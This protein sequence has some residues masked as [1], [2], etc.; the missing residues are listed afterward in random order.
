LIA[1]S[2]RCWNCSQ[3]KD[4]LAKLSLGVAIFL[5]AQLGGYLNRKC[6][7]APGFETLWKGY[8]RFSDMVEII[9]LDRVAKSKKR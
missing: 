5:I 9:K 8:A 3:K 6:D 4:G 2:A 1:A 7:R